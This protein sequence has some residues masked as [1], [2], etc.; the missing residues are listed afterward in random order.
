VNAN[1]PTAAIIATNP[2]LNRFLVF[3]VDAQQYALRLESV[4][5][6]VRMVEITPLPKAPDIVLGVINLAGSVTPVLSPRR[7]LG[8]P[9]KEIGLDAN[10]IIAST[11]TRRVALAVD[12]VTKLEERLSEEIVEAETVAPGTRF[13]TSIVNLEDGI[14]FIHDLDRFLSGEE[15]TQLNDLLTQ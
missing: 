1:C 13:T 7:R 3:T 5:R 9:E 10:L 6:V 2:M 15:E 14:L 12:S 4:Q 8:L 11:A